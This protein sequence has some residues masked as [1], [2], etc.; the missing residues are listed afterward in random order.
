MPDQPYTS[1]IYYA[2]ALD[3]VH[4]GTGGYRL[5]RVDNTILREP[6]TNIPKIPG[7]SMSGVAR[8]YTAMQSTYQKNN[9]TKYK[10]PDCAGKGGED[11]S[12]HC[13]QYN[14]PV[15]VT[16]GFS[17]SGS[18]FQGLAQFSDVRILFFPV[19]SMVGPVWVTTP[20]LLKEHGI[21]DAIL[22]NEDKIKLVKGFTVEGNRINLGWL[23]LELES[24]DFF[25]IGSSLNRS[26]IPTEILKR[27]VLLSEKLFS[28][29]VNDN[30]EVRTSVAINPATGAAES[31]ALYTY[32]AIPRTTILWFNVVYSKPDF[33]KINNQT[34]TVNPQ[35]EVE[36]GLK[37]IEALGIGGMGTRGMGRMKVL[38][39]K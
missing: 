24:E 14:C 32:E 2:I 13:G 21:N 25:D 36:K 15:C 26:C 1:I 28:R 10:Y 34:P 8:T 39:L 23:M 22:S 7:T 20:S 11:G 12:G 33:F 30:L 3:P 35:P 37:I 27:V 31:G 29:I 19:Y 16:Y 17:K 5:G 38:N 18:S 9:Q 4:I 6:G